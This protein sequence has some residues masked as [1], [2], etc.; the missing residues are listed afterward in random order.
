M[1]LLGASNGMSDGGHANGVA[2]EDHQEQR[3]AEDKRETN[4][5]IVG[6]RPKKRV[7][8]S[9]RDYAAFASREM[10]DIETALEVDHM[11]LDYLLY[12]AIGACLDRN[13][14]SICLTQA[15]QFLRLFQGRY[16]AYRPDQELHFR[17]LL[18]QL[19][20]LVTQR[21]VRCP[22]T[23]AKSS[24]QSL[25]DSNQTRARTWIGDA[26]RLPTVDAN[27]KP[28]DSA[29]PVTAEELEENRAHVLRSIDIPPEDHVYEDAFYGT[30]ECVSLLDL[31]PLF[32]RISGACY[33]MFSCPPT[34]TWMRLAAAWMLQAC[35]EQYLIWGASGSDAIDE[36][37][38]W[39]P[40]RPED[41]QEEGED[42]TGEAPKIHDRRRDEN[43]FCLDMDGEDAE[44]WKDI[45]TRALE[46]ILSAKDQYW[47]DLVSHLAAVSERHP[48]AK[49]DKE[50]V[51]FLKS[52]AECIPEP[53]LV[54]LQKGQLRG[55]SKEETSA[56]IRQ[57]GIDIAELFASV[58]AHG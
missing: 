36:A 44:L 42:M 4:G 10:D 25:R 27:T 12:Q 18:L 6:E 58:D 21:Y 31:L 11:I 56:F 54:Q 13:N 28:F 24:L 50:I 47:K 23:P 43:P 39:G 48:L 26:S 8:L 45:R 46:T 1:I 15:D 22:A 40:K 7:K 16:P 34:D 2:M 33:T 29:L 3:Q 30:S 35:L 52:L 55:M 41:F 32:M 38:A 37:F 19:V 14:V 49:T 51:G 9:G 17:Q 20:T 5:E 53:V 57:C